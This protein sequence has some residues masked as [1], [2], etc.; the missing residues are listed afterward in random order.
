[1]IS[2]FIVRA[3][4]FLGAD[5]KFFFAVFLTR[6]KWHSRR[7]AFLLSWNKR[8]QLREQRISKDISIKWHSLRLAFLLSWSSDEDINCKSLSTNV[9]YLPLVELTRRFLVAPRRTSRHIFHLFEFLGCFKLS[10]C[11]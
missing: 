7:L 2:I 4:Q 11:S 1:M 3:Q 10:S 9:V 6:I 8:Y 5:Q